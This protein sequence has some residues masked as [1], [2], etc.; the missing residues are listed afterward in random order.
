MKKE[1]KNT[2]QKNKD[3]KLRKFSFERLKQSIAK[4]MDKSMDSKDK[5]DTSIKAKLVRMFAIIIAVMIGVSVAIFIYS[6]N[7]TNTYD[8]LIENIILT[9]NIIDDNMQT[10]REVRNYLGEPTAEVKQRIED[11]NK[12][13]NGYISTLKKRITDE[14]SVSALEGLERINNNYQDKVAEAVTNVDTGKLA[15]DKLDEL[16]DFSEIMAENAK[17]LIGSQ[18]R[19][20]SGIRQQIMI[21][22]TV[23]TA[24]ALAAIVVVAAIS[25]IS[26]LRFTSKL[27]G[28]LKIVA[29][30]AVQISQGDLN[31][32]KVTIDTK[33]ELRVLSEAFNT[34]AD[35]LRSIIEQLAQNSIDVSN[36]AEQLTASAEQ[37]SKA[38][39]QIAA[40]IQ[41]MAHGAADQSEQ[42]AVTAEAAKKILVSSQKIAENTK[43]ATETSD[44]ANETASAGNEKIKSVIEQINILKEQMDATAKVTNKLNERSKEIGEIVEVITNIAS[45]TN[46]LALNAAIEAARAGE[47]GR[48]FAVVADE[49]RK[50]AEGSASAAKEITKMIQEIQQDT[51][52]TAENMEKGMEEVNLGTRL[53]QEA[54]AAFEDIV[55]VIKIVNEQ[56]NGIDNEI[57][58]VVEQI[59]TVENL[60]GNIAVIAKQ[61]SA[62]SQEV[63]AAV[64]EQTASLQEIVS[65]ASVLSQMAEDLKDI[66][67]RFKL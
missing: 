56:I 25:L 52:S 37:S 46:L 65:S 2:E 32:D 28:T 39:E 58:D 13:V 21:Q 64:E 5:K 45:Q 4:S 44:L 26:A 41:E 31:V 35:N 22:Q 34:M 60:S 23:M 42:S 67:N 7:A 57:K 48:G 40:T 17:T 8:Q 50:L 3:K 62:G 53:T 6:Y 18:L 11:L 55:R 59:K 30:E 49:V 43:T 63:A 61:S 51:I 47:H 15:V 9:N 16:G 19:F 10:T 36:S 29:T 14:E 33:D 24:V 38:S 27:A 54:G 12:N 66:V 20:S 1:Q